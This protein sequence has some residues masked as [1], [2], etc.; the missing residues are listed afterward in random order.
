GVGTDGSVGDLGQGE[1]VEQ[2]ACGTACLG[3]ARAQ[4]AGDEQQVLPSG[5]VRV[6]G[7]ELP[8]EAD[9]APDAVGLRPHVETEDA[10]GS[11]RGSQER[12]E[13]PYGGRLA[14]AVGTQQAEHGPGRC[15]QVQAGH[16][17]GRT[18]PLG[19]GVRLDGGRC[20]RRRRSVA[21]CRPSMI[22]R[23][24]SSKWEPGGVVAAAAASTLNPA[25]PGSGRRLRWDAVRSALIAIAWPITYS[26][27]HKATCKA[28]ELGRPS[29]AILS[30][31]RTA[32]S[33]A[34]CERTGRAPYSGI[35]F[36]C[37]SSASR[38]AVP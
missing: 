18:E 38:R 9:D 11:A 28:V 3:A 36:G 5:Q 22:A 1:A 27:T 37:A 30:R 20:H 19:K 21:R 29:S 33:T 2:V 25:E 8:G 26:L 17:G 23:R 16:G 31:P 13:H 4:E 7:G 24:P 34:S 14:R 6:D 32:H 15:R 10:G 12:G 35:A